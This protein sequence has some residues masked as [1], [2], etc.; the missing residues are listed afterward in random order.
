MQR[1][2]GDNQNDYTGQGTVAQVAGEERQSFNEV[3]LL[4]ESIAGVMTVCGVNLFDPFSL[5][6][7]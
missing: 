2:S 4:P 3:L 1:R 6:R 5:G 7:K